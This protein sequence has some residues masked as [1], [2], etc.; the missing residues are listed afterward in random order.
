MHNPSSTQDRNI[1]TK[2]LSDVRDLLTQI[3]QKASNQQLSA[4]MGKLEEMIA[5]VRK[6]LDEGIQSLQAH[7]KWDTFTIA[8]YG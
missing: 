2:V 7:A 3:P 1:H 8:F 6:D 4:A 5:P